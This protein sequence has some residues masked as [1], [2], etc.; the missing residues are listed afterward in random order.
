M[1]ELKMLFIDAD[2]QYIAQM[3][4]AHTMVGFARTNNVHRS[5]FLP[6]RKSRWTKNV[7]VVRT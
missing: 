4:K 3:S 7:R 2:C 1:F 5:F 6:P